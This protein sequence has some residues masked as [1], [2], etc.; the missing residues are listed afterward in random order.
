[1]DDTTT[2]IDSILLMVCPMDTNSET[3]EALSAIS[4]LII[5]DEET[6]KLFSSANH[7]ELLEL[8]TAELQALYDVKLTK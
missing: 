8:I 7:A 4:S 2:D 5:R 3:L 6:I 1:M